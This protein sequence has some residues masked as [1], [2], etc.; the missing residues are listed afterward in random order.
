M[1]KPTDIAGYIAGFPP[2]TQAVLEQIRAT[3]RANAPNTE[4]SIS[5]AIPTFKLNGKALIYFAGYAHHVSLYPIPK[6][7]AALQQALAPHKAGKGTLRFPLDT[8]LPLAL[9]TQVVKARSKELV[10]GKA[11]T[12]RC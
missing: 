7:D 1:S 8:K 4:E 2:D 12:K 3:I 6:G 5:Y 10:G 9:I 11:T